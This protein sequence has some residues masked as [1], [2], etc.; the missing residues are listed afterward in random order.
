MSLSTKERDA[1]PESDFA[2]PGKRQLPMHD[3]THVR[4]AHDMIN[5]T[6]GL[7]PEEKSEAE[8]RI[9]ERAHKL[10]IDTKDWN[11]AALD[12]IGAMRLQGMAIELPHVKN[13]P[14][15]LPFSGI[16]TRLDEPSDN[17]LH[18]SQ[19]KKVVLTTSAAEKALSSLMGMSIDFTEDLEGH[20][21]R[22]K[23]GLITGA[24]IQGNA[25]HIEGF[26]YQADFPLEVKNIQANKDHL[27]FSY[28]IQ[29]IHVRSMN[30]N[31]LIIESCMFTGAA[32]LYKDCAAYEST[33]LAAKAVKP[34]RKFMSTK[35]ENDVNV[36]ELI[37]SLSNQVQKLEEA[38]KKDIRNEGMSAASLMH[39]VKPHADKLRAAADGMCAAGIGM[40]HKGGHVARLNHMAD[41]MESEA[42][43]GKLPHIYQTDDFYNASSASNEKVEDS[44]AIKE[45][46]SSLES[47]ATQLADMKKAQFAASAEPERKTL[48]P[49][50]QQFLSKA[51]LHG[52]ANSVDEKLPLH[53][54]DEAFAKTNMTN[55]QKMQVKMEL[56]AAG[57]LS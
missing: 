38:Q 24:T 31:P 7:T 46:K 36:M 1:L 4:L 54:V 14:N 6:H 34:E 42:A 52:A 26:F 33:S 48:S 56:H 17:A 28:E 29:D 53:V 9:L 23:I 49:L 2:V 12:I 57:K 20:N 19:G 45:L 18:G 41:Q 44:V 55:Q 13:H 22:N 37:K 50:V 15:K 30:D 21:P 16:L 32:V 11:A 5:R 27:G 3:E 35:D 25:V 10:G 8:R 43:M 47:I 40:H 51:S 39:M